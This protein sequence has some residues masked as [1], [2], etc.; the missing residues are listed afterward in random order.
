VSMDNNLN[1]DSEKYFGLGV[2]AFNFK[3]QNTQPV[4]QRLMLFDASGLNMEWAQQP[5]FVGINTAGSSVS[6]E[7]MAKS[8]FSYPL[9][10]KGIIYRVDVGDVQ[11]QMDRSFLDFSRCAID[12]SVKR[13]GD[14]QPNYLRRNWFFQDNLIVMTGDIEVNQNTALTIDIEKNTT[15]DLVFLVDSID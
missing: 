1:F 6:P 10:L 9:N 5:P 13:A 2:T 3:F 12:G 15:L 11:I 14:I 4:R 8:T 7:T